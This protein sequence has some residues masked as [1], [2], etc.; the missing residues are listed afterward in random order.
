MSG[1][2]LKNKEHNFV[3]WNPHVVSW[4]PHENSWGSEI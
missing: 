3:S 2:Y 4:N 1:E